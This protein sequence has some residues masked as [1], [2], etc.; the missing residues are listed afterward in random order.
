MNGDECCGNCKFFIGNEDDGACR[1]YPPRNI[2]VRGPGKHNDGVMS[3]FPEQDSENWCGE[4]APKK[5]GLA[6]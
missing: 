3:L 1:R 4:L 2:L 6:I 5:A